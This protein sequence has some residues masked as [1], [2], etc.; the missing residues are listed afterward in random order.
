MR[1]KIPL[2]SRSLL[3]TLLLV[4][5]ISG[6]SAGC[7]NIAKKDE[8]LTE[9]REAY[10]VA[11]AHQGTANLEALSKAKTAL[12]NA[13]NAET[14]EEIKHFAYLTKQQAQIAVSVAERQRTER[15]R[16]RIVGQKSRFKKPILETR[17]T[18]VSI[19]PQLQKQLNNW[20]QR[21]TGRLT[22]TLNEA[23]ENDSSDLSIKA[24]SDIKTI[25]AFLKQNPYFR[26]LVESHTNNAGTHT[27]NLGL[28]ERRATSVK[29]ALMD[30]GITSKRITAKG[31]GETR[32]IG[33]HHT[34]QGRQK[35]RRLEII[36]VRSFQR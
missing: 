31:F 1:V 29:F 36:I 20:Q 23:F 33:S 16:E 13:E 18:S 2:N 19:N 12:E 11:A 22:I 21:Q 10:A 3:K 30:Y 6:L 9:A 32:P 28:S 27:H 34:Q 7:G 26:V 5:T 17:Q 8:L 24:Q 15:E 25:A 14:D 4:V 35:N